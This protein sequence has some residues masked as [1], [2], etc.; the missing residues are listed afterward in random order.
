[1]DVVVVSHT[2]LIVVFRG[3]PIGA[4]NVNVLQGGFRYKRGELE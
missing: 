1:M 3:S 2:V 4:G